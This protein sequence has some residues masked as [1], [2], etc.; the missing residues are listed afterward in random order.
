MSQNSGRAPFYW[1]HIQN[2]YVAKLMIMVL[3]ATVIPL[4]LVSV[5]F[6]R[7]NVTSS[8]EKILEVAQLTDNQIV[9]QMETC[10]TQMEKAADT[11]QHY[12]YR[13]PEGKKSSSEIYESFSQL[14]TDISYLEDTF[15]FSHIC[16]FLNVG[17]TFSQEGLM[18]FD[19]DQLDRFSIPKDLLL[20]DRSGS[21][22][23]YVPQQSFPFM[24]NHSY[25]PEDSIL[26]L[27]S[28][29]GSSNELKYVYFISINA[30][31]ISSLLT[32]G[33]KEASILGYLL[34]DSGTI[35]AT[36]D[37]AAAS[38]D[39]SFSDEQLEKI[40]REESFA[41][42]SSR[43]RSLKLSNG[44]FYVS[45][46]SDD[47]LHSGSDAY[48]RTFLIILIVVLP[49]LCL[50]IALLTRSLTRRI[51]QLSTAAGQTSFD[52]DQF[53]GVPVS[54]IQNIP[55]ANYD[56]VD[57][58]ALTYNQMI[59]AIE[60]NIDHITQLKA[61]EESLKY[62][63][64]QSLINPHFLYNILDSI[65]ACNRMG[66][67]ELSNKMIMD[68]TR[69]YRMTLR[70]SNELI[71]IR[72]ELEIAT[73]YMELESICRGGHFT[74]DISM[75][76]EIENFMICKFTLQPFLE[77]SILH[78][79]QGYD[80]KLHIQI[81]IRY[82]DDTILIFISDDGHGIAPDRLAELHH[83]LAAG[84]VDTSRHFGICNVNAR[85]SSEL[86]GHGFIEIDSTEGEGTSVKIEFQQI[87]PE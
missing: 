33:Y 42:E 46:I 9:Q 59:A 82:G 26:C 1:I 2:H 37:E 74:W 27:Q 64:L 25:E 14:R 6:Y 61:Q 87:L 79:M 31:Q 7:I 85:I 35:V 5:I 32:S 53:H 34:D 81:D 22:W 23:L 77:N 20:D 67:T 84:E 51:T 76:E 57:R 48:V 75:D 3:C 69:F 45:N 38:G 72:D 62:R 28:V 11:L 41:T 63:L 13:L 49:L 58:L 18:F 66:K 21:V 17:S 68:L 39:F 36:S 54:Y 47:F 55:E 16:L 29:K 71:T 70:K 65:A 19:M 15:N 24:L 73:L 80:K 40:S 86:F 60:E 83:S 50:T 56:E 44:W 4:I 30:K 10:F 78:G 52:Q 8:Y 43:Y 12:V